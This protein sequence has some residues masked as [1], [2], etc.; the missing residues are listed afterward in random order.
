MDAPELTAAGCGRLSIELASRALARTALMA[1]TSL[2]QA[3]ELIAS[4]PGKVVVTGMGKSGLVGRKIS[5]TLTSTGTTAVFLHPAEAVHG[6]L[7]VYAPGDVTILLSNSG[8]T[9]ELVRLLPTLKRFDSP[10][11]GIVGNAASPLGRAV[12]VLLDSSV[13]REGDPHSMVPTT[14]CIVALALGDA[15]AVA[16][17]ARN[18]FTP[19]DFGVFH[20]GGQIGRNLLMRVRD[21][22]HSGDEVAWVSTGD[23]VKDVVIAMTQ[24]PLGAACVVD[25]GRRLAGLITDGD[26]RRALRNHD[27]L[28]P[29]TAAAIMTARPLTASPDLRLDAAL[30]LMEDRPS[31]ISVLPVVA[32]GSGQAL[33][34]LRLH[35]ILLGRTGQS[36][37]K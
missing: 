11:I 32:P 36:K 21:V 30:R 2:G 22:M 35:D 17:M 8:S 29:L 31:Q 7:G 18:G 5:A 16:L 37:T 25:S 13:E 9:E 34:L 14:S 6:D 4:N 27:D 15:L 19:E 10:L 26:L 24:R 12:D 23:S 1:E 28:R 20:P 3:V 33:G